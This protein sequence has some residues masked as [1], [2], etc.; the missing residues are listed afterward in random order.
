MTGSVRVPAHFCGI[1]GLKPTTGRVPDAG[2]LPVTVGPFSLA[3]SLGPMA[4]RVEDLALLF[5]VLAGEGTAEPMSAMTS[6][7]R[8]GHARNLL[9]GRRVAWYTDDG[10]VPVTEETRRAVESAAR[11]LDAAGLPVGEERPPGVERAPDLWTALF[12][13]ASLHQLREV[14]AGHEEMAGDFVRAMLRVSVDRVQPPTLDEFI[15]AWI[16]RDR[17]RASLVRWMNTRPL[18]IAP[19]GA[20][21]AFEHGARKVFVGEKSLSVFRAFSYSQT[22]NVFGLPAACVPVGRSPEGLP[23]GVQI[24]GRPFDE[25][26]VLAAASIIEETLGGYQPPLALF[27]GGHNPL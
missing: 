6:D 2:H 12:S 20:V 16:E 8:R 23:I 17:L 15:D 1:C 21:P 22:F 7:A 4:R 27:S 13:R 14:Y 18:I 24:V 3:A 5:D 19:V 10:V 26:A 11:A 25:E 9:R